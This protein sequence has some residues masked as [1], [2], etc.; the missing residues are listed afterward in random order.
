MRKTIEIVKVERVEVGKNEDSESEIV[1]KDA[2][3]EKKASSETNATRCQVDQ[4]RR[5]I[6]HSIIMS[7]D[8]G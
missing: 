4:C 6:Y 5:L 3:K 2:E 8:F 7:A 1:K